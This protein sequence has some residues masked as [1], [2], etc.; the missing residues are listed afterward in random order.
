VKMRD[1]NVGRGRNAN[2]RDITW[3]SEA[4]CGVVTFIGGA[5]EHLRDQPNV[6]PGVTGVTWGRSLCGEFESGLMFRLEHGAECS[7][8]NI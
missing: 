8:W 2:E 1:R 3:A 4:R 6:S 7:S 5:R